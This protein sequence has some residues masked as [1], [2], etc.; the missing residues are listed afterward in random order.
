MLL[1]VLIG[2]GGGQT[3]DHLAAQPSREEEGAGAGV[4]SAAA[5]SCKAAGGLNLGAALDRQLKRREREMRREWLRGKKKGPEQG[6][7]R[8]QL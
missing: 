7:H 6:W 2:R 3:R 5:L 8:R 1:A 4:A